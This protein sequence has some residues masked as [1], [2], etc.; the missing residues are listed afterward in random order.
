MSNA[1]TQGRELLQGLPDRP[2]EVRDE[3]GDTITVGAGSYL[4]N[5]GSYFSID[6]IVEYDVYSD[7]EEERERRYR[8]A[9]FIAEAPT[10]IEELIAE[11]EAL[12][13]QLGRPTPPPGAQ[14]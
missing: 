11:N 5:P 14:F 1:A 3:D 12:K 8:I 7:T 10:L 9:R 13:T 4:R 2:W 6:L